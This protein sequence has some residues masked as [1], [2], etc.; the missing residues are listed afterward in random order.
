MRKQIPL[1]EPYFSGRELAYVKQV[2]ASGKIDAGGEFTQATE[3]LLAKLIASPHV[4]LISSCSA[5]LEMA[6]CLL[7]LEPGDEIIA[8]SFTFVTTVSSFAR[9]GARPV[10]VDIRPD[11]CNI[12]ERLVEAAITP[13]TRAIVP[14]HYAGV[15]AELDALRA[16]ADKHGVL[17]I[18]DAAQALHAKYDGRA[19][20]TVGQLA[21]F[22]FHETKNF[23]C[24]EGGA[25]CVND[26]ELVDRAYVIRDKGTNRRAFIDGRV[27]KYTWVDMGASYVLS[28]I[29]AAVLKAQLEA[30]VDI[31][32]MRKALYSNYIGAL[33]SLEDTGRLSLPSI[34]TQCTSNYHL[35]H[36]LLKEPYRQSDMLNYLRGR[37]I[38]AS[39]HYIPL[40]SAPQGRRLGG[41]RFELPV[42]D[43]VS[44]SIVRLPLFPGMTSD[45]Q[46]R[47]VDA[48][49]EFFEK[50]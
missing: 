15:P 2:F 49:H 36:F 20:G 19:A 10:F 40:H 26:P 48:V 45:E 4:F 35:F 37:G 21:T 33:G 16:I 25:L 8:P 43:M 39:F 18:E 47:V 34:P 46:D 42:T 9:F 38:G 44:R 29:N 6:A 23:V 27:D 24:G 13:R 22:S 11:T 3:A 50:H 30:V 7:N 5:A 41:D 32:R 17:L 12:D 31:T 14:V 1:A 28:E